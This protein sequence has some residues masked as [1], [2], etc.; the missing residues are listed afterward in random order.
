MAPPHRATQEEAAKPLTRRLADLQ[1]YMQDEQERHT[2]LED[3][4]EDLRARHE[5]L[6]ELCRAQGPK[7]GSALA[8]PPRSSALIALSAISKCWG[9]ESETHI[10]MTS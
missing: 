2:D 4:L 8:G 1:R 5:D 6:K 3:A 7:R 10:I 9:L